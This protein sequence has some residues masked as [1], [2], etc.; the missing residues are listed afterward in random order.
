VG[1]ALFFVAGCGG[2]GF[3]LGVEDAARVAA[4]A[5]AAQKAATIVDRAPKSNAAAELSRLAR[6]AKVEHPTSANAEL[7]R[8]VLNTVT[9]KVVCDLI[10]GNQ[11]RDKSELSAY[12]TKTAQDAGIKLFAGDASTLASLAL[13]A[14]DGKPSTVSTCDQLK[15]ATDF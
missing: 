14:A 4:E 1:T 3:R 5:G 10:D 13:N 2:E 15:H 8:E 6:N 7:T 9:W 11:P 12:L